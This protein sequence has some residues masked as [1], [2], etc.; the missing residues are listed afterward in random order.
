MTLNCFHQNEWANFVQVTKAIQILEQ[1]RDKGGKRG[2]SVNT[3]SI[4]DLI[5]ESRSVWSSDDQTLPV[6]ASHSEMG[7][8]VAMILDQ[9]GCDSEMWSPRQ[10]RVVD[11][12]FVIKCPQSER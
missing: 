7:N 5:M 11:H 3:W 2:E 10:S 9:A 8:K 4:S 1:Y 6:D 12:C